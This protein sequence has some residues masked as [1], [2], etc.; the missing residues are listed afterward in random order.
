LVI[1]VGDDLGKHNLSRGLRYRHAR[2]ENDRPSEQFDPRGR[3]RVA[4][5]SDP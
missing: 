3:N 1:Q 4:A 2:D 5:R